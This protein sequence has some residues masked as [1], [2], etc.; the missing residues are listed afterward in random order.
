MEKF[1]KLME[2]IRKIFMEIFK[3]IKLNIGNKRK[4]WKYN[5]VMR[6]QNPKII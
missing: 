2:K 6:I 1:Q 5:N 3:I 4:N